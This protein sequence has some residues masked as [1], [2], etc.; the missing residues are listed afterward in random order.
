[1]EIIKDI[2]QGSDE[3]LQMR[4]GSIGG[5]G[6]NIVAS[7]GK[8]R[9]QYVYKIASEIVTG[10]S[11]EEYKFKYADRGHEYEQEAIDY[12]CFKTD[13]EV[14][15][16][17]MVRVDEHRH[18]SPDGLIDPNGKIEVKVRLPHVFAELIDKRYVPTATRRQ[19]QWGLSCCDRDWSDYIQYCPE[20]ALVGLNPMV[21]ER[22]E[23]DEKEIETLLAAYHEFMDAVELVCKKLRSA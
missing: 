4:C 10:V 18:Y 20:M 21:V 15:R 22:I 13:T 14:E 17:G 8:Q 1:M 16:V 19:I 9:D 6:I 3:W 11:V 23:R 2:A 5:T 12:Y 7:K